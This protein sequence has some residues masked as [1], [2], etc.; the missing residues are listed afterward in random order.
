M[1]GKENWKKSLGIGF[2]LLLF[3]TLWPVKKILFSS[4]LFKPHLLILT[5]E[6]EL[7]PCGGFVTAVGEF[8]IIPPKIWLKNSYALAPF[9]FGKVQKPLN[10][11]ADRQKFWD[12]GVNPDMKV[13]SETFKT[14]YNDTF[15]E[16]VESVIFGNISVVEAVL[17]ILGII[18]VNNIEIS[19][20]NFFST[21]S[22]SV[23]DIDR[24][25]E[26]T[27]ETRKS[28]LSEIAKS[29]V[30]K[31]LWQFWKWPQIT[32]IIA[33][34][35]ESGDLFLSQYSENYTPYPQDFGVIEWNLGG[36]KTSRVLRKILKLN[37]R[38][39]MPNNWTLVGNFSAENV[40]GQDEPIGQIWKGGFEFLIP[41]IFGTDIEFIQT[42]IA[43]GSKF[44]HEFTFQYQGNLNELNIFTPRGQRL[45]ADISVSVY[46]QQ[47]ITD[48]NLNVR[49]NSADFFGELT[50][51]NTRFVWATVKD[52]LAPFLTF[53][54]RI[55]TDNLS[56][57]LQKQFS[58]ANFVVEIH[59]NEFVKIGGN[60]T[61]KLVD[62]NFTDKGITENM[63]LKTFELLSDGTT[64]LLGFNQEIPQPEER[65]FLELTGIKD[66]FGNTF[67]PKQNTVIDR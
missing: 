43:P 47:R 45:F 30:K 27:L 60:F 32:K 8:Q 53:Y 23:A 52:E 33:K 18:N 14:A 58:D 56:L 36:G 31:S 37:V 48:T 51:K 42:E 63:T 44:T 13:C 17:N 4:F 39:N 20:D 59:T 38:E 3:I 7:R 49:E 65:F 28:V 67:E 57:D 6:A 66:S 19:A 62:Q 21:V 24:H 5:N 16:D 50:Y 35:I 22:R 55:L 54:Q 40:G 64:I 12:L 2:I 10:L 1:K 11:V 29:S 9:D 15:R 26:N 61:A 25:N 46:P 34:N 41:E